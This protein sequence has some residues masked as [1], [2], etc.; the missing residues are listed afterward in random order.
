MRW[1]SP[2][3]YR[4]LAPSRQVRRFAGSQASTRGSRARF[5]GSQASTR[6]SRARFAGSQVR[7]RRTT[8]ES[9]EG[10][11]L[12]GRRRLRPG[13]QARM[14]AS[15]PAAR[16]D[17]CTNRPEW[18][19]EPTQRADRTPARTDGARTTRFGTVARMGRIG[20]NGHELDAA[21]S[22]RTSPNAGLLARTR[23]GDPLRRANE[24]S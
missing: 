3:Q 24:G 22:A 20:R 17:D 18:R 1:G 5:A 6:C 12:S 19:P 10:S 16:M 14:H 13:T 7:R 23:E 21:M 11:A 15:M 9:R 4:G 8:G 2:G